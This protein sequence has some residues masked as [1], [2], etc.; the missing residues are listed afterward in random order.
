MGRG[1]SGEP[2][3]LKGRGSALPAPSRGRK[4]GATRR[5]S[6]VYAVPA[7]ET[8]TKEAGA[9]RKRKGFAGAQ[10]GKDSYG[11]NPGQN[12]RTAER[13]VRQEKA[14]VLEGAEVHATALV[15]GGE[16]PISIRIL[17]CG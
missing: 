2:Q 6:E 13:L 8:L 16:S 4:G 17:D 3:I 12:L 1:S 5:W 7:P 14:A 10:N 15:D 9:S 11:S